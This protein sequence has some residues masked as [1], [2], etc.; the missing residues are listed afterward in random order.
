MYKQIHTWVAQDFSSGFK[1]WWLK[2]KL[3]PSGVDF[4][5]KGGLL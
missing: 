5:N 3:D 1:L 4:K 2:G